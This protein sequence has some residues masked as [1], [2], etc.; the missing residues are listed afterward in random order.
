MAMRLPVVLSSGA[1]TGIA[2]QDG[3]EFIVAVDDEDFAS[4][5]IG[6]LKNPARAVAIGTAARRFVMGKQ[7][8]QT[9]LAPLERMFGPAKPQPLRR[10][11]A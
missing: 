1:A 3:S 8:W 5:V 2:A 9:A 7:S 6:L 10:N 4:K 11:A